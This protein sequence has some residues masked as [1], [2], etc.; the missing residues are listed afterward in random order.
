M[1][2][3]CV[4]GTPNH[5]H[6]RWPRE[7]QVVVTTV[8][9]AVLAYRIILFQRE[10]SLSHCT[11]VSTE[12]VPLSILSFFSGRVRPRPYNVFVIGLQIPGLDL[13]IVANHLQNIGTI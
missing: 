7:P 12:C 13:Q 8:F 4:G 6:Y 11:G 1:H 5:A 2:Y 9:I 3:N 10:L